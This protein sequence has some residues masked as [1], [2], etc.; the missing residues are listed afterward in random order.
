MQTLYFYDL[1]TS[2]FNARSDRIMQFAGQ[3]TNMSLEPIGDPDNILVKLSPDILPSADA[4]L[5]T[6]ITPQQT[7][8]EGISEA[9][10]TKHFMSKIARPG[11]IFAGFNTVRFD[12]EFMRSTLYRNFFDPYEWQWKD[13]R[14]RWDLL[15]V[16]RMARALRPDGI[17]WPKDKDGKPTNRLE[18]LTAEN[19]LGH[20]NAHDA[21]SDV[22]ATIELAK[23]LKSKQPELFN[24]L[25]ETRGKKEVAKLVMSGQPF[26]YSSGRYSA[27]FE[28]TA[29]VA[30]VAER[31]KKQGA[32]VFD[33]RYDPAKFADFTPEQ[34]VESWKYDPKNPD[35]KRLPAK[36]IR[37]NR[38]PAVAPMGVFDES[39]QDRLK[40]DIK[41]IERNLA[42][43]RGMQSFA[44][45]LQKAVDILDD[46]QQTQFI[47]QESS[48]EEQIYEG[49]YSDADRNL[50]EDFQQS[51]PE[52]LTD[53]TVKFRDKRLRKM[54]PL[55]KARNF[56]KNLTEQEMEAW[57]Q[58]KKKTLLEGS[59]NKVEQFIANLGELA[60]TRTTKNEQF[61]L[62]ELQLYA[63][64]LLQDIAA[65]Y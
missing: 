53:F 15:D 7:L 9:E 36:T 51:D 55:Y 12:D 40:L 60:K 45:N 46:Q 65:D 20:E 19:N 6:G 29:V 63:E 58:H 10:F 13:S 54:V 48:A 18:L 38:C 21:L 42:K 57:Q 62:E 47:K 44:R 39:C 43:L 23:L 31:S 32:I 1:E 35:K 59:P 22:L 61:L 64:S 30:M 34:I 14:S 16:V 50:L 56:E 37:F 27:D 11:T 17:K 8:Q 52:K 5:V 41:T 3:R 26:V 2:G 24:Y 28:K 25:L 4:I 33:L 49:F